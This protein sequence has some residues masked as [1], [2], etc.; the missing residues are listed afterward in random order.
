MEQDELIFVLLS[1]SVINVFFSVRW[2]L[3][4]GHY[5]TL[6]KCFFG[7]LHKQNRTSIV[8]K[9][10]RPSVYEAPNLMKNL[11]MPEVLKK[12]IAQSSSMWRS[13]CVFALAVSGLL[14]TGP[15]SSIFVALAAGGGG[16]AEEGN[17]AP[18]DQ[19]IITLRHGW[20]K[21][22]LLT[23][24]KV[25]WFPAEW[26]EWE[27]EKCPL[28]LQLT[29]HAPPS[30]TCEWCLTA[31]CYFNP[32]DVPLSRLPLIT[33]SRTLFI[34]FKCL[35]FLL[36]H[37]STPQYKAT[38]SSILRYCRH[39]CPTSV[40]RQHICCPLLPEISLFL[41]NFPSNCQLFPF[42]ACQWF[43]CI[44]IWLQNVI[45]SASTGVQSSAQHER[46]AGR[47]SVSGP[48]HRWRYTHTA[49]ISTVTVPLMCFWNEPLYHVEL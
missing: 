26:W 18:S 13:E 16:H 20:L 9:K 31:R 42:S 12:T 40:H 23:A 11:E 48:R 44:L 4:T 7:W 49:D 28:I 32:A 30:N 10:E 14:I 19:T 22:Q 41:Q 34:V 17:K 2:G 24:W 3:K 25:V 36:S 29:V 8:K 46:T 37:F 33:L 38:G 27:M 43:Y 21:T 6:W 5:T 45:C 39:S 1:V 35:H 47:N 15:E